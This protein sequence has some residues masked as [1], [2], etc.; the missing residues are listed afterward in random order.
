MD[1]FR[2]E[3]QFPWSRIFIVPAAVALVSILVFIIFFKG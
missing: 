1:K 2:N 3:E